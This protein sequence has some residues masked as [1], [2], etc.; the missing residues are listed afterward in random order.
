MALA[1]SRLSEV[2][3]Q[4]PSTVIVIVIVIAIVIVIVIV[5]VIIS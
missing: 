1:L 5:I 4:P 2:W 3:Q